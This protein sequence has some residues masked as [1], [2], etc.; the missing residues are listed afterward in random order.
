[1]GRKVEEPL[2]IDFEGLQAYLRSKTRV[3]M[4]VDGDEYYI[5]HT[6]GYWRVQDCGKLNDKGRFTDCSELVATMPEVIEL[7]FRDGKSI[8]DLFDQAVFYESDQE[9]WE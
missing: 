7:P 4:D 8:H 3:F 2:E 5:T 9:G 1:M 6:D